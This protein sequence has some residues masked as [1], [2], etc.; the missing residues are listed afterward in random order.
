MGHTEHIKGLKLEGLW[1]KLRE[2]MLYPES[3]TQ[4]KIMLHLPAGFSLAWLNTT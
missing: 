4:N 1:G 3:K 2:E